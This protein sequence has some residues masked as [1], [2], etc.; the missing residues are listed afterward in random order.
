MRLRFGVVL[1]LLLVVLSS[2]YGCKCNAESTWTFQHP[3]TGSTSRDQ[4]TIQPGPADGKDTTIYCP[5]TGYDYHNDGTRY[6]IQTNQPGYPNKILIQFPLDAIPSNAAV[7]SA[8][9][10]LYMENYY[11]SYGLSI[12]CYRIMVPWVE[13]TGN[14]TI[15]NDGAN[16]YT[17]DGSTSW[18][19]AGMGAG[20]DY[21]ATPVATTTVTTISWYSWDITNL[22]NGWR[23]GTYPNYGV[24]LMGTSSST[25][26]KSFFSSDYSVTTVRPR[27]V[28]TYSIDTT[29]PVT[30]ATLTGTLG[31]NNWYISSVIMTLTPTDPS[32]SGGGPLTTY[33]RI[34]NGSYT[35]Y[36][37]P[38][39]F[40]S[41][42]EYFVNYY[43]VDGAG[44]QEAP[45]SIYFRIDTTAPTT[46]HT[47]T[48]TGGNNNWYS[49]DVVCTLSGTD[50][51][52][53]MAGVYYSMDGAPETPYTSPFVISS[54]GIHTLVYYGRDNAGNSE[55][56]HTVEIKI[57]KDLPTTNHALSGTISTDGWYL[58]DVTCTLNGTDPTSGIYRILYRINGGTEN[59]YTGPFIITGEGI[60]TVDYHGEDYA[61][62]QEQAHGFQ[63]KIDA[64]SPV[65][66]HTLTGTTGEN[67]WYISDVNV[68]IIAT[69]GG[70]QVNKTYYRINGGGWQIY[71]APFKISQEG[72]HTVEYYSTDMAGNIEKTKSFNLGIDKSP[73]VISCQVKGT[74]SGF[75]SWY[76]SEVTVYLNASDGISGIAG[77]LYSINNGTYT[78]YTQPLKFSE[79]I[80]F[81]KF[82]A[83]DVAGNKEAERNLLLK[84][85]TAS[86]AITHVLPEPTGKNG[87]YVRNVVFELNA[88]DELSGVGG[89]YYSVDGG[90]ATLYTVPVTISK[91][92]YT[93][94]SYWASDKV[95]HIS[96]AGFFEIWLDKTPP[97]VT[98]NISGKSGKNGWI[99]SSATMKLDAIDQVSGL[100]KLYYRINGGTYTEYSSAL[101]FKNDGRYNITVYAV[102][103]A[104][105]EA[106]A[107]SFY[108]KIDTTPPVISHNP[109][110]EWLYLE[111]LR[112]AAQCADENTITIVALYYRVGKSDWKNI[113]MVK[114]GQDYTGTIGKD[115]VKLDGIEYYIT[116][117]DEAGNQAVLPYGSPDSSPYHVNVHINYWYLV[118]LVLIVL[119]LLLFLAFA[120]RRRFREPLKPVGGTGAVAPPTCPVCRF[121]IRA[122]ADAYKC[123]GCG[124]ITHANCMIRNKLCPACNLPMQVL[125]ERSRV[126]DKAK[127]KKD[128]CGICVYPLEPGD[129]AY[130]CV[131]G[132]VYHGKCI[133]EL[134]HCP[135]C[136]REIR[137]M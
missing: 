75:E 48:G 17:R 51:L 84:I 119:L 72:T 131:C 18:G 49:S 7:S 77:V 16:W 132:A 4:I 127:D 19:T 76:I 71:T 58:S 118:I 108:V 37:S 22:V 113:E 42:G 121:P 34:N 45:K 66:T 38:V 135:A 85:D 61:G 109:V 73:P 64:T 92:G 96:D 129:E 123:P 56:Q 52:S 59:V 65:S 120:K 128:I 105:N 74:S 122:G 107:K 95:G 43:S 115:E 9:L 126:V 78:Q 20:V 102:D 100:E 86:P 133:L 69:D 10:Q 68:A 134:K 29:P 103:S 110:S 2:L 89:L 47:L 83:K 8:T 60:H 15:T 26:W 101:T 40:Y 116:A 97:E 81:I 106:R 87:W 94:V 21:D 82:Y 14:R 130:R 36:T 39:S 114:E 98:A 32:P 70:S 35:P 5:T 6:N 25:Y 124:T 111:D 136:K 28:V 57:D 23:A 67:G 11:D 125:V 54:P 91:E 55:S 50:A 63:V 27:L 44:N 137:V 90:E 12:A 3:E 1:V 62:N 88:S 24:V 31:N 46:T 112:I 30:T 53:G 104:G 41:D 99:V 80:Y 93:N 33:C 79:G 117:E 13:G